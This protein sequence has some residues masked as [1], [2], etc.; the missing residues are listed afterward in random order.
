MRRPHVVLVSTLGSRAGHRPA[1][2]L[3]PMWS[4]GVVASWLVAC[5]SSESTNKPTS[6]AAVD[7]TTC[8]ADLAPRHPVPYR[9]S[10]QECATLEGC[11]E[12]C[13]SG[14]GDACFEVALTMQD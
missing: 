8:A 11:I 2:M 10:L 5:A 7:L 6:D 1:V 13:R 9:T 12:A 3:G 14:V 4:V